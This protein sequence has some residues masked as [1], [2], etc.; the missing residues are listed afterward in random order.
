MILTFLPADC[1]ATHFKN[2]DIIAAAK[3]WYPDAESLSD[4]DFGA[5]TE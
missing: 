5:I 1:G 2:P 4:I 3:A